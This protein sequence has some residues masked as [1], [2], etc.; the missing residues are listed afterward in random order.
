MYY[1]QWRRVLLAAVGMVLL[2]NPALAYPHGGP[3]EVT[4]NF[5]ATELDE[6]LKQTI[7]SDERSAPKTDTWVAQRALTYGAFPDRLPPARQRVL[8]CRYPDLFQRLCAYAEEFGPNGSRV[9]END[10][11]VPLGDDGQ[12]VMEY[13]YEFVYLDDER[14]Y[15]PRT[16]IEND[17]VVFSFDHAPPTVV[18]ERLARPYQRLPPVT[19]RAVDTGNTTKTFMVYPLDDEAQHRVDLLDAYDREMVKKNGRYYELNVTTVERRPVVDRSLRVLLR[20]AGV[21]VGL[22]LLARSGRRP[23]RPADNRDVPEQ[24]RSRR[25]RR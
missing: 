14:F 22:Y 21:V 19:Q 12:P 11:A 3:E 8:Y 6:D 9:I 4:M 13:P 25:S 5:E 15:E 24:Q 16:S 17:S 20:V 18:A 1:Y 23:R 10:T 2:L 7:V